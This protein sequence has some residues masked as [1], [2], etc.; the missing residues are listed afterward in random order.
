METIGLLAERDNQHLEQALSCSVA[1]MGQ[2]SE[3]GL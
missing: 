2:V 1:S 3:V